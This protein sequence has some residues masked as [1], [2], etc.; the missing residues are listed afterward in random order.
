MK[1]IMYRWK[2]HQHKAIYESLLQ[3]GHQVYEY[4]L[5]ISNPEDDENYIEMLIAYLD[6]EHFDF[7][8]SINYFPVLSTACKEAGIPYV[9]W[10]C[11]SP[12]LAMRHNSVFNACN[13]IFVFDGSDYRTFQS[14][15]AK[16]IYY[17]PLGASTSAVTPKKWEYS[18]SFVGN[19]YTKNE[20]DEI[21]PSLSPYLSGYLDCALEAQL[22][23]SGGNLL[24]QLLNPEICEEL[25]QI[26]YYHKSEE[27]F[28]TLRLLFA[29]TVL[30]FKAASLERTRCLNRLSRLLIP[31]R[32]KLLSEEDG[33]HL[34]TDAPPDEW[35]ELPAELP[36][37]KL[38][39]A[40]SYDTELPAVI[41]SSR[42]NLNF[43]IPN[44]QTGL[45]LRI[46]DVMGAGGFL[47]SNEQE[48][49][50][51]LLKPGQE[52]ECFASTE[53][54]MDK[55]FFYLKQEDARQKIARQGLKTVQQAHTVGHRT[56]KLLSLLRENI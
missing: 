7:L 30:G 56:R 47:L 24:Y 19:L 49:I 41:G 6:R 32:G 20:Y 38:H 55:T 31:M 37:V 5:P 48:E 39:G 23:I 11:D 18:V 12:L 51:S 50:S 9:S 45:P 54:L 43:T 8:F 21:L 3:A 26:S 28:S 44:I 27:S 25:E 53:E 22:Q 13:Y 42:I 29:N 35:K 1:I 46:W 40:V 14:L 16:H 52:L 10:T 15:G 4:S 36:L 33:V 17:L 2:A 34:F